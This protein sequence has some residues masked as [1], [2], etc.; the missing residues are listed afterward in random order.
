MILLYVE[1]SANDMSK[2][3][4]YNYAEPYVNVCSSHFAEA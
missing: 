2:G 1:L 4:I 3:L